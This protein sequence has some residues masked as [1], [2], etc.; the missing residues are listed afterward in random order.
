EL[1][2]KYDDNEALRPN[3]PLSDRNNHT[4]IYW[5]KYSGGK[6]L[7]RGSARNERVRIVSHIPNHNSK[8]ETVHEVGMPVSERRFLKPRDNRASESLAQQ[9]YYNSVAQYKGIGRTGAMVGAWST[10]DPVKVE[11]GIG[12]N[13]PFRA[14]RSSC[15]ACTGIFLVDIAAE[16]QETS[17][18][19]IYSP[20]LNGAS[21]IFA[22]TISEVHADEN[23]V[24]ASKQ[25]VP[26]ALAY[27]DDVPN[28]FISALQA[29]MA[30]NPETGHTYLENESGELLIFNLQNHDGSFGLPYMLAGRVDMPYIHT[31]GL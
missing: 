20:L 21:E 26:Q 12:T 3:I 17:D 6:I 11:E 10:I 19:F 24:L 31:Y 18:V 27:S 16:L 23:F 5:A 29:E 14:A 2:L 7:R 30:I 9:V 8:V 15:T 1:L 13:Y 25:G 4:Y 28:G 22:G